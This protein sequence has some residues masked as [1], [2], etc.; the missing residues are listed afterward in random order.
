MNLKTT[1][2]LFGILAAVLLVAAVSLMTGS[3]A[4]EEGLLLGKLRARGI[5]AKDIT[6]VTVE[7]KQPTEGKLVFVRED[8]DRWKLVEPYSAQ[9]DGSQVERIVSD[10]LSARTETKGAD[11]TS[12][13]AHFGLDQTSMSVTLAKDDDPLVTVYLAKISFGSADNSF[14]YV[15]TTNHKEPAAVKRSALGAL[16]R[17]TPNAATAGELFRAAADFLPKD[18]L[19]AHTFNPTDVVRKV[20]VKG[21]KTEIVLD[22]TS[23]GTWQYEKPAGYGEADVEGDLAGSAGDK[24]PTGVRPLLT[25]LSSIRASSAEDF[26]ENVTDFKHYGLDPASPAGPKIEVVRNNPS[27]ADAPAITETLTVGKK[28]EK[29]DRVFVRPGNEPIV[30]KVPESQVEPVRK[31]LDKPGALRDRTLLHTVTSSVDGLDIQVGN[32]PP[33]ELRKVG[34]PPAWKVFGAN[35]AAVNANASAIT[36]LL[37]ELSRPHLIKEFPESAATD[38]ALGFDHPTAVLTIWSGGV[39]PSEEK[40]P[41]EKKE[42]KK[43]EAK[44]NDKGKE[45]GKDQAKDQ[46]KDAKKEE[47]KKDEGPAK[48][49]MK[50]PTVKLIF[51][52]RDKDLL[53]VQRVAN[54]VKTNAAVPESL[55]GQVTRGR[56]D[57]LDPT[58]PSFTTDK[59]EK[60]T[61]TRGGETY[62]VE[63]QQKDDKSPVTW[64]FRQ[65]SQLAGRSAD[66]SKVMQILGDLAGQR[67]ERLWAEKATDH[68]LERFGL[69]PPHVQAT[70]T[71]KDEKDKERVYLFGNETNDKSQVYAKQGERDLVF[72]TRKGVLDALQ[73]TDLID[74]VVFRFDLAKAKGMK[75]SGWKDVVGQVTTLDLERKGANNWSVKAPA[76]YKL[77]ASQAE[78]FLGLL[79]AVRAERFVSFKSGPKPEY[80]L[81]PDA[82]AL[83]VEL[84][85]DGEKESV[86]LTLG[87]EAEGKYYYAQSSKAPGDVFLLP[88]ERF[89]KF[90][91]RPGVFAAK[92]MDTPMGKPSPFAGIT[93]AQWLTLAAALMGWLFDGFEMGVFPIVA[94]PALRDLLGGAAANLDAAAAEEMV[95]RWNAVLSAVFLFGASAGGLLFG[96]LGDRIGRVRAMVASVLTYALLT[97]FCALAASPLQLAALRFLAATGM[98]GEWALGVAL[99]METWPAHTRP[100]LA[101]LIGASGNLGYTA[102]A[103][104]ALV[105]TPEGYWRVLLVVCVLPALLTFLLR[106]FVPE[107]EAW[108]HAAASAPKSRLVDAFAPGLGGR[109]FVGAAAGAVALLATWGAVQF[110][111]LWAG[112]M[113]Q[114]DPDLHRRAGAYVQLVSASAA[115]LG[116]FLAPV[117]LHRLSRRAGYFLLCLVSLAASEFLFLANDHFDARF[118]LGVAVTGVTTAAFYGWLP[119]YLPELFP[120]RVR[121]AGQGFCYNAGRSLAAVGVLL[122]TF[123]IDVQGRY[124]QASALVCLVYV[125]GLGLAWLLPE[126][127]GKPLPE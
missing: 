103:A 93:R 41:E 18:L 4:G 30:V 20:T 43:E 116:A 100:M 117:L 16:L 73:Q 106:M 15:N 48:P 34:T 52:K 80:K 112:K 33:I 22:K 114:D 40:K 111:Q 8:K 120:T 91:G 68:E 44:D 75:L 2:W 77:S 39:L 122:T 26:I 90:K 71:L 83:Q 12:N 61:F 72:S 109:V 101:G 31:L 56:L 1:Y 113:T 92:R 84:T 38:A 86:A 24:S 46:G 88:K 28:E 95:R 107:S 63:K 59:A 47:P 110:T 65:P 102:V 94:R 89:E 98:G 78:S 81:T 55:L 17:D 96:W 51:G 45:K 53:Y 87:A 25:A 76:G 119:L 21:D 42:E 69:K 67:A 6:R 104:L 36:A 57:Y 64:V 126:T 82:G 108:R 7:R 79:Q 23:A 5:E 66:P 74:L 127:S 11:L 62:V 60:L 37:T 10:L 58:L 121:A 115:T 49:K 9:A 70:V 14:V 118:L 97:G 124:A 54:N 99:V 123:R 125:V 50:E 105:I 27:S 19:L 85:L 3:K 32:D 13:P 35:T 29:G